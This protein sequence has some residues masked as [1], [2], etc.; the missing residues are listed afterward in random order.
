MKIHGQTDS[1]SEIDFV[2]P[3]INDLQAMGCL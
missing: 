2:K 1:V 3:I